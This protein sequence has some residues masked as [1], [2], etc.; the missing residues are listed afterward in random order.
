ME[1]AQEMNWASIS[2]GA[3]VLSA[4]VGAGVALFWEVVLGALIQGGNISQFWY[5]MMYVTCIPIRLTFVAWWLVPVLNATIYALFV[6]VVSNTVWRFRRF[7][8]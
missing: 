6:Y 7:A 1:K 3:I 8:I 2:K 4:L 5:V